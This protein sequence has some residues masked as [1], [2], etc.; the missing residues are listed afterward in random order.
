MNLLKPPRRC[1]CVAR[2]PYQFFD[3]GAERGLSQHLSK[4]VARDSLQDDPRIVSELPQHWI[5]TPPDR[6]SGMIPRPAH[7]QGELR[8][9]VGSLDVARHDAL[10]R[11]THART[12]PRDDERTLEA[13]RGR[14]AASLLRFIDQTTWHAWPS[15]PQTIALP[16]THPRN[17][18]RVPNSV[19]INSSS[20]M[21]TNHDGPGKCQ[22]LSI[23]SSPQP[24]GPGAAG[25]AAARLAS[26]AAQA[27]GSAGDR[28]ELAGLQARL[29]ARMPRP[30]AKAL[31]NAIHASWI[32]SASPVSLRTSACVRA[33]VL[34]AIIHSNSS[35]V[36][37]AEGGAPFTA[38]A[39]PTPRHR[40]KQDLSRSQER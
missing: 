6:V 13:S 31:A 26:A 16:S 8:Q 28:H 29:G 2:G 1:V 5:E 34:Y 36:G 30:R 25:G 27:R 39:L 18:S 40:A 22:N 10:D 21:R 37:R 4:R 38:R 33:V 9:G 7:V 19:P 11:G 17:A 12:C 3:E 24:R 14:T 23:P 32:T 15:C 20:Q 35:I